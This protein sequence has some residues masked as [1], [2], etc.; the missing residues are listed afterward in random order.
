MNKKERQNQILALIGASPVRS[1]TELA[2]KLREL[3]FKVTQASVSR[4]LDEMGIAKV[5]GTYVLDKRPAAEPGFGNI[6]FDTAGENLLVGRCLPGLASAI[7]VKIDQ[8]RIP[9]IV[10]T[11]AGDDTIFIAVRDKEGQMA[12]L[13]AITDLFAI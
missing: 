12:A 9:E 11:I 5:D 7:T 8:A 4:D 13:K 3:G 1:Q 10:G 2:S 6:S